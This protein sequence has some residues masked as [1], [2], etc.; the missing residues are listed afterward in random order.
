MNEHLSS[1]ESD[2]LVGPLLL[3]L[4]TSLDGE[5]L[6]LHAGTKPCVVTESRFVELASEPLSIDHLKR[7]IT[8][9]L[10]A[11]E[12]DAL[13]R[14]GSV[15]LEFATNGSEGERFTLIVTSRADAAW[16]EI[17]RHRTDR[18]S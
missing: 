8:R 11:S 14:H 7:I 18:A 9:V 1:A 12:Q 17:L 6:M 13:A 15:R 10:P 4:I 3:R 16:L 2:T 5:A